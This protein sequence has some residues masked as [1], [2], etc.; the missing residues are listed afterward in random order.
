MAT[1]ETPTEKAERLAAGT[2]TVLDGP[3]GMAECGCPNR[4]D[5]TPPMLH[6][7]RACGYEGGYD[8]VHG[9]CRGCA[10]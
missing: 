1:T 7:C 3:V 8:D 9:E 2:S 10:T 6:I 5:G 4:V